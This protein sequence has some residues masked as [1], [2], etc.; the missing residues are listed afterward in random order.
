M[1]SALSRLRLRL[2]APE[3]QGTLPSS[4]KMVLFRSGEACS[5]LYPSVSTNPRNPRHFGSIEGGEHS[6]SERVLVDEIKESLIFIIGFIHD[7]EHN[8]CFLYFL[9]SKAEF[10]TASL[11]H[12]HSSLQ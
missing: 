11:R 12:F 8:H 10:D 3:D 6:V 1:G 5:E 2:N 7:E 4:W 9:A